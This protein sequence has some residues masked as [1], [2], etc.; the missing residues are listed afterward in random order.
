MTTRSDD[1]LI[2]AVDLLLP[3]LLQGMD[4]VSFIGRH[5]HPPLLESLVEQME[6]VAAKLKE[7][8]GP[9]DAVAWPEHL[10]AFAAQVNKA[11]AEP[12]AVF[13]GLRGAVGIAL[14]VEDQHRVFALEPVAVHRAGSLGETA[15]DIERRW[16]GLALGQ[17]GVGRRL[18]AAGAERERGGAEP[19]RLEARRHDRAPGPVVGPD[20][21]RDEGQGAEEGDP[22]GQR[23]IRG[24]PHRHLARRGQGHPEPPVPYT[25]PTPPTN[26][27]A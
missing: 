18:A 15:V 9:F 19:A 6:P 12:E 14:D 4:A 13:A 26:H 8:R 11:A 2:D 5:L 21:H 25:H 7:A 20:R 22:V 17:S 23:E 1:G 3:A 24:R 10:V 27:P 16:R